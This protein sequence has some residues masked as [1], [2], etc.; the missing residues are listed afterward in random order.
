MKLPMLKSGLKMAGQP[1]PQ[2]E[3]CDRIRG[4]KWMAIRERI[5]RRD[6]GLCQRC[7]RAGKV[8]QGTQIDHIK[9]LAN[10]GSNDDDNLEV[11]CV[12]CHEVKTT[13]DIGDA[14]KVTT[15]LDGWPAEIQPGRGPVWRRKGYE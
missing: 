7:S 8:K 11:I 6:C 9:A 10:G 1:I 3:S 15:G 4:R 5:F 13:E 14:T 2:T 12:A